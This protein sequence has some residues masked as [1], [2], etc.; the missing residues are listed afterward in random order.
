VNHGKQLCDN[1]GER[2]AVTQSTQ[3]IIT[4]L[5]TIVNHDE[6]L[7]ALLPNFL[8]LVHPPALL[9]LSSREKVVSDIP[10][11]SLFPRRPV[12]AGNWLRRRRGVPLRSFGRG[13]KFYQIT[14]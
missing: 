4:Q 13:R 2:S 7:S 8:I 12:R 1:G 9:V 3:G 6:K 11:K 10:G 14:R 5:E